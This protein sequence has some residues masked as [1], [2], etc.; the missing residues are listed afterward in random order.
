MGEEVDGQREVILKRAIPG[1]RRKAL[2]WKYY[3]HLKLVI[4][5][6]Q[7]QINHFIG[8]P[9]S[10]IPITVKNSLMR[11]TVRDIDSYA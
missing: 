5:H 6:K 10:K 4:P 2:Y 3:K 7:N 1:R 9:I 8:A 11:V